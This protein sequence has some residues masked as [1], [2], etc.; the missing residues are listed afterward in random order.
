VAVESNGRVIIHDKLVKN[1]ERSSSGYCLEELKNIMKESKLLVHQNIITM[2]PVC[3]LGLRFCVEVE[4]LSYEIFTS[5]NL[6]GKTHITN[7]VSGECS[8]T[9]GRNN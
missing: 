6:K 5:Q 8:T 3:L 7:A 4:F 2:L 1:E 9:G